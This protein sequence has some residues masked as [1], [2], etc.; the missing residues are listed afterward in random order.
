MCRNIELINTSALIILDLPRPRFWESHHGIARVL[1]PPQRGLQMVRWA[2]KIEGETASDSKLFDETNL[3]FSRPGSFEHMQ[4]WRIAMPKYVQR[5][6]SQSDDVRSSGF[7]MHSPT[8]FLRVLQ[9]RVLR[10]GLGRARRLLPSGTDLLRIKVRH[11]RA[12]W[13]N[14]DPQSQ[15]LSETLEE[16][17]ALPARVLSR[18]SVASC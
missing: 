4:V 7:H 6:D 3:K 13:T 10:P 17:P 5:T 18:H 12:P 9:R 14:V 15:R 16:V 11:S 8:G 2:Q 1:H